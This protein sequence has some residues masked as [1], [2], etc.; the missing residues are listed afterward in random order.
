MY[1]QAFEKKNS[2]G[3]INFLEAVTTLEID[4]SDITV[5]TNAGFLLLLLCTHTCGLAEAVGV[6]EHDVESGKE[7]FVFFCAM[8]RKVS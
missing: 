7:P 8:K 4:L 2:Q 5:R 6:Q 3:I 1:M